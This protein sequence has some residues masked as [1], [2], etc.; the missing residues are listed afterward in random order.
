MSD[1][2]QGNDELEMPAFFSIGP[3]HGWD[4]LTAAE[5]RKL[6]SSPQFVAAFDANFPPRYRWKDQRVPRKW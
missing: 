3:H 2:I 6:E 4:V 1:S 5:E